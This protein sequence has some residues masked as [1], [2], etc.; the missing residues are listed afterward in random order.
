MM[1]ARFI[2]AIGPIAMTASRRASLKQ[3][4][5]VR[6]LRRR[7]D[8]DR[9]AQSPIRLGAAVRRT[10]GDDDEIARL[11]LHFLVAEPNRPGALED[12]LHLVG[13]EMTML[14]RVAGPAPRR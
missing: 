8:C 10:L 3:L 13:V 14:G 1:Q 2:T 12:V 6:G 7:L 9:L 5:V 11:H 4:G